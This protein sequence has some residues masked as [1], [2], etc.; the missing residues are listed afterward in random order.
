M[1]CIHHLIFEVVLIT[2][3]QTNYLLFLRQYKKRISK[4]SKFQ[5][6]KNKIKSLLLTFF[7]VISVG[8]SQQKDQSL[9]LVLP[10]QDT[11]PFLE[12]PILKR[13]Y[14]TS[15]P[16]NR[17]DGIALG[18]LG[19]DGGIRDSI[20]KLVN[21]IAF[22]KKG[23][24]TSFLIGHRGKLLFES[25]YRKGR[26]DL[27]HPQASAVK[28]YTS[29]A[30]GRAIQ[31]GYLTMADLHKPIL[32]FFKGLNTSKMVEGVEKITLH[33]LLTMQSG[34]YFT[35]E[36][37]KEMDTR[38]SELQGQKQL[39]FQLENMDPVTNKGQIF[40]YGIGPGYVMQVLNAVTPNGAKE[41][42]K[43][44]LLDKL[45]IENYQW[46]TAS[47]GLPEAGWR[48]RFTSRDMMKWGVLVSNKGKWDQEQLIAPEYLQKAISR[49]LYVGDKDINWGGKD[50][51]NQGY[52][53][54]F[55]SADLK[56]G[57]RTYFYSSAQGGGG[58]FIAYVEELDLI[59]VFTA[60]DNNVQYP[61]IIAEEILPFFITKERIKK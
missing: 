45:G 5:K 57:N 27:P 20:Y 34:I 56:V 25:Y 4:M 39:Q 52:G 41:F 19:I 47:N 44:E 22:D 43:Y 40:K 21:K 51:M 58:Q 42:I 10:G 35:E 11:I 23:M 3:S 26:M 46:E 17:N 14:V 12:M 28:V 6:M 18:E 13:P 54:Y 60:Y 53:Y 49:I 32:S 2:D 33:H 31:L 30:V 59:I 29:L 24:F 37:L 16:V 61:Q 38:S 15:K 1:K 9:P 48:V 8:F 7:M 50:V 55:W 36:D